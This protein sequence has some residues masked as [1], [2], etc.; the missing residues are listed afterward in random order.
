[1]AQADS[2]LG[3]EAQEAAIAAYAKSIG[4]TIAASFTEVESGRKNDRPELKKALEHAH[5]TGSVLVIAKLDR[6]SRNAAFLMALQESGV[7][8]V[9]AD[10]PSANEMTVG[11]MALV[12]AQESRAISART[13]SALQ[14]A[15]ARGTKLGN[16]NGAAALRRA[17]KGNTASTAARQDAANAAA[18]QLR[19][20]LTQ[21]H[22][23]G[24]TSLQAVA[25]HFN[26]V[27]IKTPRQQTIIKR[28][29]IRG[30]EPPAT[31]P[32]KWYAPSVRNLIARLEA[33]A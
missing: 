14:A 8:F 30:E 21:A 27:G 2:G 24:H 4:A 7:R 31:L 22:E 20:Q 13:R 23:K 15:K 29:Q 10:M 3:L 17:N 28:H 9:A 19:N 11:V 6:L 18:Q 32:G 25:N 16:P 26:K 1:M 12:A 33:A 5:A